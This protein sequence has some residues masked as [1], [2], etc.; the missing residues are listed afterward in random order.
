MKK[1]ILGIDIGTS[2]IRGCIVARDIPGQTEQILTSVQ[3]SLP[4]P[5]ANENGEIFQSPQLWLDA[6]QNLFS[7]L[8]AKYDLQQLTH[9]IIDATSSTVLLMNQHGQALT[10]AMMYN[11][12]SSTH[13]ATLIQQRIQSVQSPSGLGALGV[14]STLAKA[15]RLTEGLGKQVSH[16]YVICHQ[17]DYIIHYLTGVFAITDE[18][19]ALKLGF[20]S[21][22][23]TWPDWVKQLTVEHSLQLPKVV[24]PGAFLSRISSN[25]AQKFGFN[26][27]LQ[28]MAGTTDSIAGFLAS[29][30]N[31]LGDAVSSLG[32]TLAIKFISDKPVFNSQYGLYSHRLGEFWLV[33]GASN[34]G[35]KVL[36]NFYTT[37]QLEQLTRALNPIELNRYIDEQVIYYPLTAPGERFPIADPDKQPVIPSIPE[38]D[39]PVIT[40]H[41]QPCY[42]R[43]REFAARLSLGLAQVEQLAYQKLTAITE[44]KLERLYSVGGG[45]QNRV[46]QQ[47]RQEILTNTFDCSLETAEQLDAA[48][49]VTKLVSD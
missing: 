12:N 47:F 11:D 17:V 20:D 25:Q 3:V 28:I 19:N 49:G 36:L 45:I 10:S 23:F 21:V 30:A 44:N 26:Q 5:A 43:H 6:L 39:L 27:E 31:R 18:N 13:A 37:S 41:S 34:C 24:K 35:G 40:D 4:I 16:P 46:W 14:S 33:G 32:S 1:N 2:G 38:C 9:L 42:D 48:F 7:E 22:E 8:T 29:G 15:I